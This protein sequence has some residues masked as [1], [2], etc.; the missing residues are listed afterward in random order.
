MTISVILSVHKGKPYIEQA[1]Q[2]ILAQTYQDVEFLVVDDGSTDGSD[3]L[4]RE[5]ASKDDRIRI[6]T[7]QTNLGLTKSLNLALHEARGDYIARMDAD[8][9]ALPTRLEKQLNFLQAHPDIGMV[10]TAFEW[11]DDNGVV[12]GKPTIITDSTLLH[13]SLIRTNPFLHSSVL[14]RK[15]LLDRVQGYNEQFKKAQDYDLWLRLS[16]ICR[17]ANL[18]EILMQKRMSKHMISFKNEREQLR[19]AVHARWN[20]LS[21]GD[22]P[23][24]TL[25][26]LVK[27]WIASVLP[28][29]IVRWVRIHLFGQKIYAHSALN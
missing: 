16:S 26:Y 3:D 18:P 2:S 25:L 8:D 23:L 11:I 19:F 20:A 14:I 21:R 9:I 28:R 5:I 22:Y 12:I 10:G 1:I 17:F 15:Q 24:W 29:S 27:P 13:S 7:N 6:I 4:L